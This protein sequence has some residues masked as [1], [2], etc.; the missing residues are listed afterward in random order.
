MYFATLYYHDR[1]ARPIPLY[2]I[3]CHAYTYYHVYVFLLLNKIV[4]F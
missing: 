4:E 2:N 1:Y 3:Y